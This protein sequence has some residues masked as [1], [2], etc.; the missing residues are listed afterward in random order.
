MVQFEAIIKIN[1]R[2][3]L[4]LHYIIPY[5]SKKQLNILKLWLKQNQS[6][7]LT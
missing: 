5:N 7:F 6:L 4:K 1:Y 2:I 3:R